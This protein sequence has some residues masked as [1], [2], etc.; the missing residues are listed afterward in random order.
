MSDFDTFGT[1]SDDSSSVYENGT[2]YEI[3]EQGELLHQ[4]MQ[5]AVEERKKY[6]AMRAA[7]QAKA[8]HEE[9]RLERLRLRESVLKL[10]Q[11]IV[12]LQ[13]ARDRVRD[14]RNS[15]RQE[16]VA[17]TSNFIDFYIKTQAAFASEYD[18]KTLEDV[19]S[20]VVTDNTELRCPACLEGPTK[21]LHGQRFCH[22]GWKHGDEDPTP[23]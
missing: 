5:L 15:S 13:E 16:T 9:L 10:R 17:L 23:F 12:R 3:A 4:R 20:S 19:L 11:E 1:Y 21:T 14:Q 22:C 18:R 7:Y 6:E 8:A 2:P